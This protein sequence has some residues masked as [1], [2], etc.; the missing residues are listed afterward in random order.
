MRWI[1]FEET[2]ILIISSMDIE[3][4]DIDEIIL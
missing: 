2:Q 4:I 1:G 3:D